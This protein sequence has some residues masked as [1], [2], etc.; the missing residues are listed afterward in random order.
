MDFSELIF[1]FE[2]IKKIKIKAKNGYIFV[3]DPRGCDV[4]C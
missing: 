1:L 4:A 3:W 2:S